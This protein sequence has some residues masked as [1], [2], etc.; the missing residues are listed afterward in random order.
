MSTE[1]F[2]GDY[3]AALTFNLDRPFESAQF[4][5]QCRAR[6][7]PVML[8]SLHH[9][10][11]GVAH[12]LSSGSTGFRRICAWLVGNRPI[13]YETMLTFLKV[14]TRK[15]RPNTLLDLRYISTAKA[16]HSLLS[17]TM[18]LLASSAGEAAAIRSC[19]HQI[20]LQYA[21]VPHILEV[22]RAAPAAQSVPRDIDVLC[23]GRIE[24]RKNQLQ[25]AKLARRFPNARFVFI[26]TPSP[27]EASYFDSF[28]AEI[29]GQSNIEH[30][31]S[32]SL[33]KLRVML[34]RSRI[35]V[36][37]S[38]FEV[39]SLTELEAY[40]SGCALLVGSYSYAAEFAPS[41]ATFITPNDADAAFVE[42]TRLLAATPSRLP[43]RDA[44]GSPALYRME[45][46]Q[47]LSAFDAVF[48]KLG[49]TT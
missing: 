1:S 18:M 49:L 10:D 20:H 8:Y 24:S 9:P 30:F 45:P 32:M 38:W 22:L 19:F 34:R 2:D 12:Y 48:A 27:T 35:F 7:I 28:Q 29:S 33:D 4:A 39:V 47:V 40:A 26:G 5:A 3:D 11:S 42:L 6:G 37:L 16:Q 25:V 13:A 36:S 21:V 14:V 43:P 23:A 46:T 15:F 44:V 31:P 41:D 17:N